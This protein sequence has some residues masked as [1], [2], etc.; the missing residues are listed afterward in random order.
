MASAPSQPDDLI[1]LLRAGEAPREVRLFAARAQLP[2]DREGQIRALLAVVDDPDPEIAASAVDTLR[3]TA[4]DDLSRFIASGATEEELD[5]IARISED[6]F[7]LEQ[8]IRDRQVGDGTLERLARTVTG[9]PQEALIV[10]QVRLIRHPELI[11]AL[12]ENPGLTGDGRRRLNEIREEFFEKQKRRDIEQAREEEEA[13]LAAEEAEESEEEETGAEKGEEE[14]REGAEDL[15]DSL[16]TGA[17]YKRIA[18]M[19]ISE[20]INLAYSGGK[21]ERRVL[22]G[23]SNR[24]VGLAVLKS[25]GLTINEIE[26]FCSMRHLDSE[27]F[28]KIA[29]N[30]EWARKPAILTALV[31]NPK[32][33]LA[34]AMPLVKHLPLRE[35]RSV[36]RDPNLADGLRISARKLLVEKRR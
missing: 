27:L 14:W 16:T 31:K 30:R 24:L 25:R 9:A 26:S 17:I 20:K 22:V 36:M 33:P 8:V 28:R 5:T 19:T 35:L 10:N 15:D 23:D 18:I 13:R 6:P 11:E 7:V 12:F 34:I 1:L 3:A 2:L 4:P 29:E 32:V 21:E